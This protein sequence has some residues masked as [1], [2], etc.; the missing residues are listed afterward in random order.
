MRLNQKSQHVPRVAAT[1]LVLLALLLPLPG[2]AA[3]SART[4]SPAADPD[5]STP[6][7]RRVS[8]NDD[9]RFF[10][11]DA[12]AAEQPEFDDRPWNALRLPHDWAIDGPFDPALNPHTGALPIAGI[13]WYRKTFQLV[14]GE[15]RYYAIEF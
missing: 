6:S 10:R 8:F 11:G 4:G 3:Q 15:A 14:P 5:P 2:V 7:P 13:G 9:W 12:P 1:A